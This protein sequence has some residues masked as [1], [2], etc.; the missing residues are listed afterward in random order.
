MI[1]EMFQF[2][3]GLHSPAVGGPPRIP[4]RSLLQDSEEGAGL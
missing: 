2:F 1:Q 4:V 3:K